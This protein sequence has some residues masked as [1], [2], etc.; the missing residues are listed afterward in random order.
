MNWGVVGA[1]AGA[2]GNQLRAHADRETKRQ[3]RI[4]RIKEALSLTNAQAEPKRRLIPGETPPNGMG[5]PSPEQIEEY[6]PQYAYDEEKG[7]YVRNER[8]L[9]KRPNQW[10]QS[11]IDL[12]EAGGKVITKRKERDLMGN[13]RASFEESA[14][15]PKLSK[16]TIMRGGERVDVMLD[17]DG[18]IAREISTAPRRLAG[19]GGRTEADRYGYLDKTDELQRARTEASDAM[20]RRRLADQAVAAKMREF[21]EYD[22]KDLPEAFAKAGVADMAGLKAKV[23]AAEY[24]NFGVD[25]VPQRQAGPVPR[26]SGGYLDDLDQPGVYGGGKK[27]ESGATAR[28]AKKPATK[29]ADLPPDVQEMIKAA[30]RAGFTDEQIAKSLRDEGY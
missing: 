19:E 16:S 27:A 6:V 23:R 21:S 5:P 28:S 30:R 18:N 17:P 29:T 9:S 1:I 13:T 26:S 11:D 12:D 10:T 25:Q 4:A 24:E 2:A 15:A 22:A 14:A 7:E 8:S 20:Q 3:E